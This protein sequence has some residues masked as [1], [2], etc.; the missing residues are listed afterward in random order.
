MTRGFHFAAGP[1]MLPESLLKEAQKDILN[2]Q[3]TGMSILEIGHRTAHFRDL[4]SQAETN[5]R[6]LINIPSN[7]HVLF[8][9][10]SARM[11]FSMIPMNFLAKGET[12]DYLVT[13]IWSLMA[14][15]EARKLKQGRCVVSGE[16]SG[17]TTVPPQ[18]S[19]KCNPEAAYF[20][21]T[22][23]ETVN[24]I[25]Y[26]KP[27][28]SDQIPLVADMTSCLLAEP[29][30]VEDYDLIF[31]GAQKNI[32]NAG[33]TLVIIRD[34]F[35][36]TIQHT[37][38][39]TMF[40]FRTHIEHHSLYATPPTFN[41]YLAAKMF[42]W[43]RQQGGVDALYA[44]NQQKAA[45]LYQ[46]IDESSFYTCSIEKP[47]RSLFNVC[48]KVPDASLET[49]FVEEAEKRKLYALQG[50][51]VV[52]GLRASLYNAMPMKGVLSLIDFMQDFEQR[53][54]LQA[55]RLR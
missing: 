3:Q 29:I 11:L 6:S 23:N 21:Y 41:C 54:R 36:K 34:E 35:V 18:S 33:L 37:N 39:P 30:C 14:L 25:Y 9:A 47:Y 49:L 24:G 53:T 10:G 16:N 12:A 7:Y 43:I 5:L 13:G 1:A 44:I 45:A 17:F 50:H 38:L 26:P 19:W 8:L 22:P 32:A 46:C 48:F 51:R 55:T 40:D 27:V 28:I 15:E 2:W 4:L 20:Y 42:D 31:A 52:G